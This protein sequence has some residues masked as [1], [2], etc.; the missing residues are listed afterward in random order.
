MI[1]LLKALSGSTLSIA[2]SENKILRK[3]CAPLKRGRGNIIDSLSWSVGQGP[4]ERT[5]PS[6]FPFLY[7]V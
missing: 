2:E 4:G 5:V 3:G 7:S 1:T 6:S